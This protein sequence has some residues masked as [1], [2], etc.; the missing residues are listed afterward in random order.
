MSW[1]AELSEDWRARLVFPNEIQL[2][3]S[4]ICVSF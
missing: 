1:N 4:G 3:F 2:N